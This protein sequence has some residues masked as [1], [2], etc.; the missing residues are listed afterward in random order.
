MIPSA[1]SVPGIAPYSDHPTAGTACLITG[2]IGAVA[3]APFCFGL[4]AIPLVLSSVVPFLLP[5]FILACCIFAGGATMIGYHLFT[6]QSPPKTPPDKP[7]MV[8]SPSANEGS[9]PQQ[10][11]PGLNPS[12][13]PKP[14]PMLQSS[15]ADPDQP[16]T[17]EPEPEPSP[18]PGPPGPG[19]QKYATPEA[20]P[21]F[22]GLMPPLST[23][24]PTDWLQQAYDRADNLQKMHL[25]IRLKNGRARMYML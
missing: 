15:H 14:D 20:Y 6:R 3:T 25:R 7:G 10:P 11:S 2:L 18:N 24:S 23:H 22:A 1:G 19:P 16:P 12:A 21:P 13:I 9:V 17:L 5:A 4:L 8:P